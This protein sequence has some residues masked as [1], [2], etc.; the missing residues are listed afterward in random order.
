[1]ITYPNQKTVRVHRPKYESNFLLIGHEDWT[2]ACKNLSSSTFKLFLYLADNMD[3]YKLALSRV[4][5]NDEIGISDSSYKR[6]VNELTAKGYIVQER[7]N[8][9][10]FYIVP[11]QIGPAHDDNPMIH[12]EPEKSD[13]ANAQNGPAIGAKRTDTDT[14]LNGEIDK[15]ITTTNKDKRAADASAAQGQNDPAQGDDDAVVDAA[16][17][18]LN[19]LQSLGNEQGK[20]YI[21]EGVIRR[22]RAEMG[23]T[24][25]EIGQMIL[26]RGIQG[27]I[28][29]GFD[30]L[31]EPRPCT[32]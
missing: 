26:D 21:P 6:A 25:T 11:V 16:V 28:D 1:M 23:W 31:F 22:A 19:E 30:F 10:N 2:A 18:I 12:F 7:G 17:G 4:A 29:G 20:Q 8:S 5:V 32:A 9:Y 24:N 27:L 3:G 14:N 15:Q 13:P